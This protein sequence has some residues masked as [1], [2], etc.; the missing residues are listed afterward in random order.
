MLRPDIPFGGKGDL[1]LQVSN[2]IVGSALDKK[3]LVQSSDTKVPILN[4]RNI[5]QKVRIA[6]EGDL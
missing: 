1:I 4:W 6:L 5:P 2:S 3:S